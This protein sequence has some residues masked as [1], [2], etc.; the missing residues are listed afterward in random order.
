MT[1]GMETW[2]ELTK[3]LENKVRKAQL[4]MESA[5]FEITVRDLES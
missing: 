2:K 1:F 4:L 3:A 5:M